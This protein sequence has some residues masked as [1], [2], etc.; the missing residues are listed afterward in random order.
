M[1]TQIQ[2][3]KLC[4]LILEI[5]KLEKKV[6]VV[7]QLLCEYSQFTPYTAFKRVDLRE[8]N[9]ISAYDIRQFA[10]ENNSTIPIT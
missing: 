1:I 7:R 3:Q 9:E 2:R 8:A 4:D 5:G 10:V 6:E